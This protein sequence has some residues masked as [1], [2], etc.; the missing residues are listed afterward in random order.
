MA[1]PTVVSAPR[2]YDQYFLNPKTLELTTTV[3]VAY[4]IT[5]DTAAPIF[6][7]SIPKGFEPL[8]TPAPHLYRYGDYQASTPQG[9]VAAMREAR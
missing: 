9:L 2:D 4:R 5:G 7:P 1:E 6:H 8:E 3:C